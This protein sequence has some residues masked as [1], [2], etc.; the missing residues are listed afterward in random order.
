MKI[1]QK[2]KEFFGLNKNT[3][4]DFSSLF[5]SIAQNEANKP[6]NERSKDLQA[7]I[8]TII[9]M[10]I[11]IIIFLKVPFLRNIALS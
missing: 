5:K 3:F 4:K 6:K 9:I 8:L 7:L 11:I 1:R 2:F 10:V